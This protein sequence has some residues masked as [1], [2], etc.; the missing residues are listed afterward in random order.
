MFPSFSLKVP[1]QH[2][3]LQDWWVTTLFQASFS[4]LQ[5]GFGLFMFSF[6]RLGVRLQES[7]VQLQHIVISKV[8]I[9][10]VVSL[11]NGQWSLLWVPTFVCS[12]YNSFST[13]GLHEEQNTAEVIACDLWG[14]VIRRCHG[15]C[16]ALSSSSSH[17]TWTLQQLCG[18]SPQEELKPRTATT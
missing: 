8:V 2:N 1:A 4:H 5:D 16:L 7:C 13:D 14:Q 18:E 12:P 3:Q 10:V 15:F 6:H 11:Q 9:I 17:A